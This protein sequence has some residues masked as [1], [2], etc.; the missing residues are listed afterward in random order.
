LSLVGPL[1]DGR[2][3]FKQILEIRIMATAKKTVSRKTKTRKKADQ[4]K[5][6]KAVKVMEKMLFR[7]GKE[8]KE[9]IPVL[10]KECGLSRAGAST[11][12]QTIKSRIL[13]D[14]S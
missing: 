2:H 3:V 9:I 13:E 14:E 1:P 6:D 5:M 7:Q 4:T 10:M 12:Y 11:Y 8:R